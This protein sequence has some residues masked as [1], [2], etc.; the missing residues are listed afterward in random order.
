MY[1]LEYYHYIYI[2]NI[3]FKITQIPLKG[4]ESCALSPS[5]LGHCFAG[6]RIPFGI[7]FG[8]TDINED[9]KYE[10][11]RRIMGEVLREAR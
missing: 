6:S 9:I 7:I 2:L 1:V 10:E 8:G 11:K 4:N 5:H 3:I